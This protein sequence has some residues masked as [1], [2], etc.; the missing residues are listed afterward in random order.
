LCRGTVSS[1]PTAGVY[2]ND[3]VS[4]IFGNPAPQP[5]FAARTGNPTRHRNLDAGRGP[6]AAYYLDT[7]ALSNGVHTIVWGVTDS[8]GRGE[9]IGSRY[10]TVLNGS[11][12]AVPA[13]SASY[14]GT[15]AGDAAAA[16][17]VPQ[18]AETALNAAPAAA[19]GEASALDT[20]TP[21]TGL[22]WGR[23]GFDLNSPYAEVAADETG[24]R[25]VHI[26]DLGRLELWLGAVERGYLVANGTLRDLPPGSSLT[27]DTGVFTWSPGLGYLGTYRLAFVR[28]GE[29][30]VVDVTIRPM[31]PAPSETS[32][33]Q[34]S[35]DLP[36]DGDSVSGPITVAG[37]ALDPQAWTGSGID[38]VHVWAQ[39]VDA[40]AAA[41]E[42][43][44]AAALGG[45][46]PDV[47]QAHGPTFGTTGFSLTTDALARGQYD[48][49]VFA[50]NHRT[51]RW[52]DARTVRV[53]V[54]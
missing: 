6:I 38:A 34:M 22:V 33:I 50:W 16:R 24:V 3:D 4:N 2:C 51:A 18:A 37:W 36:Q 41:P 42:F 46:R 19:R 26:R 1:P 44:G 47:A 32:G 25:R 12:D 20:L 27:I 10:F 15:S 53:T 39:R 45:S 8:A 14:G 30:I 17:G 49:T 21:A 43:L 5:T 31:A 40:A 35:V 23:T 11:A 9:G 29:Q 54:R 28:G 48:L 52:E 13:K 7:T